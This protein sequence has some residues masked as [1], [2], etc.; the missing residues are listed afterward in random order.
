MEEVRKENKL[1]VMP[2]GKLL[3]VMS[4]PTMFSMLIQALYNIVD[5]IFVSHYSEKALTAVSLAFPL[6]SLM[7][8]FSVGTSVG[9]CSV[10]SRR[11][12]EKREE[13][14]RKAGERIR[15]GHS[16]VIFPEGTR[17][18]TGVIGTFK[19]GAFRMATESGAYIVPVTV[20]GLR[21]SFEDRKR[22]FQRRDCYLHVGTPFK[23]PAASDR[24]QVAE[25]V[26]RV[27]NEVRTIYEEL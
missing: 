20:K 13:E 24:Q 11:L 3:V 1:G 9:I 27:E 15:K 5:S 12:G 25:M 17:S 6:Q 19:H 10:I 16:M 8:A 7:I 2:V 4:V 22:V 21:D 23:A 14:A 18:K 26:S